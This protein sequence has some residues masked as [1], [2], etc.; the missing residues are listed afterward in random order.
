MSFYF[1][2]KKKK[3]VLA[4][5]F[6]CYQKHIASSSVKVFWLPRKVGLEIF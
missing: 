1:F 6:S 5:A 4:A 2:L 3:E